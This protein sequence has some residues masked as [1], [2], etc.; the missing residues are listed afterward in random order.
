[1]ITN[2]RNGR[3]RP[4]GEITQASLLT[5]FVE[6]FEYSLVLSRG[7]LRIIPTLMLDDHL[8]P[9]LGSIVIPSPAL[10]Q[11][12]YQALNV[13]DFDLGRPRRKGREIGNKN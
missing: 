3:I 13:L 10:L 8:E 1:M 5:K 9:P 2:L 6:H 7:D 11:V 12:P 4:H